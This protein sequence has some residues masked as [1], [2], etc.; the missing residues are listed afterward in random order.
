MNRISSTGWQ[1]SVTSEVSEPLHTLTSSTDSASIFPEPVACWIA[2]HKG[3]EAAQVLRSTI[4]HQAPQLNA[5]RRP[6]VQPQPVLWQH[7]GMFSLS[8]APQCNISSQAQQCITAHIITPPHVHCLFK[9]VRKG[10]SMT[11]ARSLVSARPCSVSHDSRS[12][13]SWQARHARGESMSARQRA[14]LI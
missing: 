8:L 3:S 12:L 14:P 2:P 9:A 13:A 5:Q 7:S 11:I 10:F 1:F 4:T 6:R